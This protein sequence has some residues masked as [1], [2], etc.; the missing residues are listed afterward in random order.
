[1]IVPFV[2]QYIDQHSWSSWGKAQV[3]A[4]ALGNDAAL[5]G[6]LPLVMEETH[7]AAV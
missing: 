6:A 2:Q 5:L 3:K 4:A 1:M 7:G